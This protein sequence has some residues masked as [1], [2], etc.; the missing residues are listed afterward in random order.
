MVL[1]IAFQIINKIIFCKINI[2]YLLKKH[3]CINEVLIFKNFFIIKYIKEVQF[4]EKKKLVY[5]KVKIY[6]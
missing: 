2:E 1:N 5:K 4:R 6:L 3:S